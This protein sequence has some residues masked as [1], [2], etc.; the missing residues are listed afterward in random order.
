MREIYKSACFLIASIY[1]IACSENEYLLYDT[2]Q[3][4]SV[5]FSYKN[6]KNETD[7]TLTYRFEYDIANEHTIDI[8]VTLMGMPHNNT[9]KIDVEA[10]KD[11]TDMIEG[12]HYIIES[13]ELPAHSTTSVIKIKLLRDK[14]PEL[15]EREFKIRLAINENSDLRP[16]GARF[17]TIRFSDIR[18]EK[19]PEWWSSW[20]PLPKYSFEA[21]QIFFEYFYNLAPKANRDVFDEMVTAYGDYF[22]NAKEVKGPMALYDKFIIRYVLIPMYEETGDRF[23]WQRIPSM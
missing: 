22:V 7:S 20:A 17:F 16:T 12:K 14:D 18:P 3:K 4:D 5:F 11:S 21:A 9:R 8:P 19:Q 1:I 13:A 10:V 2:K 6:D 15:K 23:E